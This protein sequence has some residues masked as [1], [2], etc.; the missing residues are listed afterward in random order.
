MVIVAD[1]YD[2]FER[3]LQAAIVPFD[4]SLEPQQL[5]ALKAHFDLLV[6]ANRHLNLTR[7]TDPIEAAVKHYADSLALAAWARQAT[8]SVSTLL[9]VGTGG[10][11]PSVPL[12]V[13]R[14]DWTITAIDAREKKVRFLRDAVQAIGLRNLKVIHANT[15]HWSPSAP[16]C[17]VMFRALSA[18]NKA[19]EQAA[20]L[21]RRD[22]VV[23]AWRTAAQWQ[24]DERNVVRLAKSLHL[25][26]ADAFPY[27]LS[28]DD[29]KLER[30]I[31][32]FHRTG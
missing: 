32:V 19:L 6:T 30:V 20:G 22:G 3:T 27:C 25:D 14:P 29:E 16:F 4:L 21:V 15:R 5:D 7:I 12:A 18:L 2:T 31:A 8:V 24:S 1:S 9:D 13:A 23:A 17:V 10:G 26:T 11:F 28:L